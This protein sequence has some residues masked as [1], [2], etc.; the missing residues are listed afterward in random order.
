MGLLDVRV[1]RFFNFP[2]GKPCLRWCYANKLALINLDY[3]L[4]FPQFCAT[5]RSVLE[6]K[7]RAAISVHCKLEEA[8]ANSLVFHA[9]NYCKSYFL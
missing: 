3:S 2:A 1:N 8:K 4:S 7:C 9:G 6:V 5:S